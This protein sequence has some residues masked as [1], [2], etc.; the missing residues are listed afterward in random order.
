MQDLAALA[1]FRDVTVEERQF[2]KKFFNQLRDRPLEAD[3][4]LYVPLHQDKTLSPSDPVELMQRTIEWIP[5]E[6]IQLFSGFRG[7]GKSTELR[8]L[9]KCL[10]GAGYLVVLSDL[11]DY[12]NLTVP[13]DISDFL[14]TVAGA[15]SEGLVQAKLLDEDPAQQ[16]F[17]SRSRDFLTQSRVE[18]EVSA[19]LSPVQLKA[20]LKSDPSFK[21]RL[22]L[23]GRHG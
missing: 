21:K 17:W 10:R 7:S 20:N 18:L 2:L 1:S 5:G 4:P 13:I 6:S 8:R 22:H 3:D 23:R 14:M 11:D 15:F 19:D 9:A 16:G 12:L